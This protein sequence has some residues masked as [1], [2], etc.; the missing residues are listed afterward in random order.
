[1]IRFAGWRIIFIGV[2]L[3]IVFAGAALAFQ[4]LPSG[5]VVN[6]D[7]TRGIDP[8][9]GVSTD[10][11]A[12]ADVV[13]GA[14]TA[15]KVA[16]PWAIFR[17][18]T[19]AQDQIFSRSFAAGAWT[20]R[21]SGTVGG[22]SSAA[23]TFSA[24]LN[25]DQSQDGEAPTIDFAGT[26]RTV[27]WATWYE[28]TTGSNFGG[29]ANVF[30]SR[31]DGTTADPNFGKWL[32]EGQGRGNGGTSSVPVPSLNI[33]T[34][35]DGENPSIAGGTTGAGNAP[36]PWV[37][38]QEVDGAAGGPT[39]IFTS[40]A[41]KPTTAPTCPADGVN[42][43]RPVSAT[44]AVNTFC[45]QQVGVER[46][47]SGAT[48]L[49]ANTT[50]PSLNVDRTRNAVEPDIVFTGNGDTVP[51][52][53]WYEEGSTGVGGLDVNDMVFAAKGLPPSFSTPPTGTVDGGL[54]W[55]AVGSTGQGVLDASAGGGSCTASH[56]AE[57]ACSLDKTA[58]ANAEDPR[59]A[60]GTMTAGAS[61]A[62][63][64]VWDE[65]AGAANDNSVFVAR[66]VSGQFAI[67]NGG[68]PIGTGDRADITFSGHTPYVTWHHSG[69]VLSGHFVTPDQF[70]PDGLPVGTAATDEVRA[71][72]SSS[73]TANPFNLD[74]SA[75]QGAPIGTPFLLFTDGSSP[76]TLFAEAYA[77]SAPVTGT[78]AAVG[79]SG[80][81]L[82]GS[83]NPVGTAVSVSFQFGTS[84]AYGQ[85]T[86][87]H[88]VAAGDS[89]VP[90][91]AAISGFAQG[92]T[93]HYRMVATTDFGQFF[94]ADRTL[95]TLATPAV[96]LKL[97]KSTIKKLLAA[98]RLKVTVS[99]NEASK[100]RL[101]ASIKVKLHKHKSKTIALGRLSVSFAGRDSRTVSL[102]LSKS[103]RSKLAKLS[104]GG[105]ITVTGQ[106]TDN[107]LNSKKRSVSASYKRK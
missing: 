58:G 47:A 86:A 69:K 100:V 37:T 50:D 14:L 92:T 54:N 10:D 19:S 99:V 101:S 62:P 13:G 43:A 75:C 23:P 27:P 32:F 89:A 46:V 103:V 93:V 80:A 29:A 38:W 59:V 106:A 41:V 96:S 67:A 25:F 85:T 63:W 34:N 104:G 53:V 39:Q 87:P 95:T 49:P 33:H 17:S 74:G 65:G 55:I 70:A 105:T 107:G 7:A 9:K 51:W 6:N 61:T 16:V 15:G 72:I 56:L 79:V 66:L 12:N 64:V 84:T 52:V 57:E 73:C 68:Q 78:A 5:A 8:T 1:M 20:T 11:P 31:F 40:K 98:K 18:L 90:I 26:G 88:V 22:S 35:R 2:A 3:A 45:W 28:E 44:G 76:A 4:Q 71:P 81:T 94:G 82:N 24:S 30:A 102:K 91:S 77:P 48:T 60:A 83:V 21:G 36:V 42:P 97:S